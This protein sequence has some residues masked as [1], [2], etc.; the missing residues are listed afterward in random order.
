M[1]APVPVVTDE[2]VDAAIDVL[3]GYGHNGL[4]CD[5]TPCFATPVRR[6]LEAAAPL[7]GPRP[8]LD[9]DAVQDAITGKVFTMMGDSDPVCGTMAATDAVMELARPMPT[10]EQVAAAVHK[11]FCVTPGEP[12]HEPDEIDYDKADEILEIWALL[13]GTET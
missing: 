13:N 12:T 5:P 3:M 4:Q 11:H 7:L 8:L 9:R 10:R 1:S 6:A 2:A